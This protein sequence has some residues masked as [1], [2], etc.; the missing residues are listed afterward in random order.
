MLDQ[1]NSTAETLLG[2]LQD[3]RTLRVEWYIVI[4]IIIETALSLYELFQSYSIKP[5]NS[6]SG[7]LS[8]ADYHSSPGY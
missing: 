5:E 4:L 3:R 2:L 8:E 1:I 7:Y 6:A